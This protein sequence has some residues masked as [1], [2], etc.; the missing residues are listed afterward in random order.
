[1]GDVRPIVSSDRR[2]DGRGHAS[3]SRFRDAPADLNTP[4]SK[5]EQADKAEGT[6][7]AESGAGTPD[8]AAA[9]SHGAGRAESRFTIEQMVSEYRTLRASVTR[10]W[11]DAAGGLTRK[12]LDDLVRFN[13]AI[14][15]ALAESTAR[16]TQG[17]G[18]IMRRPR[19]CPPTQKR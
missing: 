2:S 12:D 5:G 6:G 19:Q 16:F 7:D 1:M 15:Q 14:D 8:T 11:I 4:Q 3:G 9:Q 10:L 18:S 13:E 17:L